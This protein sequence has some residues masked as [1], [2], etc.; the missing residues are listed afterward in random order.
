MRRSFAAKDEDPRGESLRDASCPFVVIA[1]KAL[2]EAR[3]D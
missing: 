1:S 2:P 3:F